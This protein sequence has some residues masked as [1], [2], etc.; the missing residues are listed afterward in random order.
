[1]RARRV[2]PVEPSPTATPADG[3]RRRLAGA[4]AVAACACALLAP[5]PARAQS[6]DADAA[7]GT[8]L[9]A[10]ERAYQRGDHAEALQYAQRAAAL[11]ATPSV[12]LLIAEEH[13]RLGHTLD[14]LA[15]VDRCLRAAEADETTP[16]RR[17]ILA[18][19]GRLRASLRARVGYLRLV[20]PP[21]A[22]DG[23]RVYLRGIEVPRSLWDVP[24]PT[25]PGS[26]LVTANAPQQSFV[27]EVVLDAGR[28]TVLR[29]ELRRV[30]APP[31]P[32]PPPPSEA[33]LALRRSLGWL[34]VQGRGRAPWVVAGVGGAILGAGAVF[35]G[36]REAALADRDAACPNARCN[37]A[38]VSAALGHHDRA[39]TFNT[40]T[41]VSIGLGVAAVVVGASWFLLGRYRASDE[42]RAAWQIDV[43]PAGGEGGA[44]LLRGAL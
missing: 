25:L 33:T 19:A 8:L 5:R 37:A 26:A 41:N 35:F 13:D 39:G 30:A 9:E 34:T 4:C 6:E 36:L 29:V 11:R 3:R 1:M 18:S 2:S 16:Q 42:R 10:A 31:P 38:G 22:P 14:A 17:Q 20:V 21:D 40:L 43:A 44:L 24:S 12:L 32:P 28:E 27:R 15:A 23:L 7:R